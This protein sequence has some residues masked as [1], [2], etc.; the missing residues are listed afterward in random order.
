VLAAVIAPMSHA[1]EFDSSHLLT[2][3]LLPEE[4]RPQAV[5]LIQLLL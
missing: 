4:P 2:Y 1:R 5:H 3:F